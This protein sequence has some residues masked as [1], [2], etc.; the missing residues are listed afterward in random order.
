MIFK[1]KIMNKRISFSWPLG[2]ILTIIF[3][4]LKLTNNIDWSWVWVLSPLWI[5]FA[6][7]LCIVLIIIAV[8]KKIG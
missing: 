1:I 5:E 4:T 2:F 7:I 3:I 8:L 6:L